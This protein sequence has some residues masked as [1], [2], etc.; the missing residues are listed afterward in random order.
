MSDKTFTDD[1]IRELVPEARK[2]EE[3]WFLVDAEGKLM[4]FTH[5]LDLLLAA[6]LELKEARERVQAM[7]RT[8]N[9]AIYFSDSHDYLSALSEVCLS[10][11]MPEDQI[12]KEF[13]EEAVAPVPPETQ[14]PS[15]AGRIL[16]YWWC[17]VCEE[18][19]DSRRVTFQECHDSCGHH[20]QWIDEKEATLTAT[21]TARIAELEGALKPFAAAFEN[22]GKRTFDELVDNPHMVE[23]NDQNQILPAG[24]NLGHYRRAF[25]A[26]HK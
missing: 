13:M 10:A 15:L 6:R 4:P 9:N 7:L 23:I 5:A 26:L 24:T 19:V 20:V 2:F 14:A 3:G 25:E 17:P 1:Q 21:L 12:G 18:E 16:G 22:N 11:M 8:A